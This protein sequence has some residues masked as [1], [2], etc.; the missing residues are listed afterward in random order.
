MIRTLDELGDRAHLVTVLRNLAI[1]FARIDEPSSVATLLGFLDQAGNP[2]F[3]AEADRLEQ[4]R[5]SG[6]DALGE[7]RWNELHALGAAMDPFTAAG[8]SIS[9]IDGLTSRI[10][11][12]QPGRDR[13]IGPSRPPGGV[14]PPR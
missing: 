6:R 12:G 4:V 1:L 2:T 7:T 8:W 14:Q 5:S 13:T 11:P 9:V 10:T 3:G